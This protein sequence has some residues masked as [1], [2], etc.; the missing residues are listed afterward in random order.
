MSARL[1]VGNL[2]PDTSSDELRELFA[3]AG[4]VQS[5][6]VITERET[7]RSKGFAFVE[8]S[9]QEMAGVAKEKFNG[10]DMRGRAIKV[11]DAKP[12]SEVLNIDRP[13]R[14]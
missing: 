1:F 10:H 2:S 13:R 4:E 8:M 3:G 7:G 11:N 9:T 5:C 12:R 6:Q 14:S